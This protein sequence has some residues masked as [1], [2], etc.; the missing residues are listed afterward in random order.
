VEWLSECVDRTSKHAGARHQPAQVLWCNLD[1]T[2]AR[3]GTYTHRHHCLTCASARSA[4]W[5]LPQTLTEAGMLSCS[6]AAGLRLSTTLRRSRRGRKRSGMD[7]H[8]LRP[9]MTAFTALPLPPPAAAAAPAVVVVTLLKCAMSSGRFHGSFPSFPMPSVPA[10]AATTMVK[11]R[12]GPS[13]MA[14]PPPPPQPV[15]LAAAAAAALAAVLRVEGI[16]G[17]VVVVVVVVGARGVLLLPAAAV[18]V[19]VAE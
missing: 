6:R 19:V 13:L 4:S 10:V 12:K 17:L 14:P 5:R 16:L 9:M 2:R 15:A 11:A 7:C 8:V 18:A 1:P 3:K